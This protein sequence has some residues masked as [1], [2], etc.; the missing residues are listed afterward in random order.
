MK[1]LGRERAETE[2]LAERADAL[3][4]ERVTAGFLRAGFEPALQALPSI[5]IIL[6]L[7]VGSWRVSTGAVTV[8]TLVQFVALFYLL[9]WPMRFIGWILGELPRALVGKRRHRRRVGR[10]D[11]GRAAEGSRCTCRS[12][13][14]ASRHRRSPIDWTGFPILRRRRPRASAP[15]NRWRSWASP[16]RARAC[17]H[18]SWF[19]WPTRTRARCSSAASTCATSIPASCGRRRRSCSRR[20]SCSPR[21]SGTTSR[22]TPGASPEEVRRA[23]RLARADA[24]I[25][26]MPHGFDTVVGERGVTLSG[27]QRQR[28]ALARALVRR[29]RIL[30]LDDATSAVD[31]TI[32]ARDPRRSAGRAP[33]DAARRRLPPVDDHARRPRAGA[34]RGQDR[35]AADDT[36]S[37]CSA[38]RDTRP[39]C[40]PT[41]PNGA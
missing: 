21:A 20:A 41:R 35:R 10:A 7:A 27:G 6:L 17:W 30:I 24:F 31:P 5:G 8:G 22:W 4:R 18:R 37:C 14:W 34:G 19:G 26:E 36:R 23:A 28:V 33:D 29:P 3:R 12:V 9:S 2:R 11:H 1:T 16:G 13:P 39:S 38:N 15:T 32:E 25:Q 40:R